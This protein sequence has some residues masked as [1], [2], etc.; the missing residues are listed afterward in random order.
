MP[1][2]YRY[3]NQAFKKNLDNARHYKRTK[4]K[5]PETIREIILAKLGLDSWPAALAL[6]IILSLLVYTAYVPNFLYVKNIQINGLKIKERQFVLAEVNSFLKSKS[7]WPQKNLLFLN[8][9]ALKKTLEKDN[10]NIQSIDSI[11]KGWRGDLSININSRYPRYF[12]QNTTQYFGI[13][14]DGIVMEISAAS[15]ST[16][17][18]LTRLDFSQ[19]SEWA[20]GQKIINDE[21]L[22]LM[23]KVTKDFPSQLKLPISRMQVQASDNQ[24]L[25]VDTQSGYLVKLDLKSDWNQTLNNLHNLF[26][27]QILPGDQKRLAYVDMRVPERA[28]VCYKNT[29][30]AMAKSAVLGNSTSTPVTNNK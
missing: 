19:I 25:W 26:F 7:L 9:G 14:A 15:S 28:Y 12:T 27:V 24:D 3:Q 20:V 30:C 23:Q 11:T 1:I 22:A 18:N 5:I 4:R 21:V 8:L 17:P 6:V 2:K 29:A 16:P 13:S 10:L